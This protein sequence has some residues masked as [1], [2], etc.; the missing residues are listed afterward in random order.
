VR[1]ALELQRTAPVMRVRI[2]VLVLVAGCYGPDPVNHQSPNS[3]CCGTSFL[4]GE[5]CDPSCVPPPGMSCYCSTTCRGIGYEVEV[6]CC[7]PLDMAIASPPLDM[8][9]RRDF[10]AAPIDGGSQD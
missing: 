4:L 3:E 6:E 9:V 7:V 10:S 5:P 1:W 8:S 2:V